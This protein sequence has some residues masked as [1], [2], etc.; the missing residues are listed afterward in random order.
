[1]KEKEKE[2]IVSELWINCKN[3]DETAKSL[4]DNVLNNRITKDEAIEFM[5]IVNKKYDDLEKK[6]ELVAELKKELLEV[7]ND[8][9]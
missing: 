7:M 4:A 3:R 9:G 2:K 1:M 8:L 6:R 5:K